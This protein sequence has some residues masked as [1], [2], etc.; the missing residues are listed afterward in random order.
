LGVAPPP[1][2]WGCPNDHTNKAATTFGFLA[3]EFSDL[4]HQNKR[5]STSGKKMEFNPPSGWHPIDGVTPL[6]RGQKH[7]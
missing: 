5:I 2:R 6:G 4:K 1:P 7:S 3:T